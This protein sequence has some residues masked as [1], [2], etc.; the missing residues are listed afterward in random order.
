[1]PN[2]NFYGMQI[3]KIDSRIEVVDPDRNVVHRLPLIDYGAVASNAEFYYNVRLSSTNNSTR[4][5]VFDETNTGLCGENAQT[6]VDLIYISTNAPIGIVA[7]YQHA[8]L[9]PAV[10]EINSIFLW[11]KDEETGQEI[12][13]YIPALPFKIFL[14]PGFASAEVTVYMVKFARS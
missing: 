10:W 14:M 4:Q 13:N 7:P 2:S 6:D 3:L 8:T 1:M 9:E 11:R 5:M 12:A